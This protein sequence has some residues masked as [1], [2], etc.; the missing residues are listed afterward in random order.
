MKVSKGILLKKHRVHISL[1]ILEQ[2]RGLIVGLE[3]LM[4]LEK[5]IITRFIKVMI[6]KMVA[7][8]FQDT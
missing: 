6:T 1:Y 2:V 5:N 3:V 7:L 8:G 4:K